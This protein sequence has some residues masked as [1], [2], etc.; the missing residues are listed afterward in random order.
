MACCECCCP[1]GKDCC[2]SQGPNGICCEPAKCCGTEQVPKCCA[3]NETCCGTACCPSDR[4]CCDGECCPQGQ[5]CVDGECSACP[6]SQTLCGEACCPDNRTCCEGV[7]CPEGECCENGECVAC[8]CDEDAD[9]ADGERCCDGVCYPSFL[10]P[11]CGGEC[12]LPPNVCCNGE[13]CDLISCRGPLSWRLANGCTPDD[14]DPTGFRGTICSNLVQYSF[15]IEQPV[16]CDGFEYDARIVYRA[17]S[18]ALPFGLRW[19][20]GYP[21]QIAPCPWTVV[22]D[23]ACVGCCKTIPGEPPSHS[24]GAEYSRTVKVLA[25]YCDGSVND[26]TADAIEGIPGEE[27]CWG[28]ITIERIYLTCVVGDPPWPA[29]TPPGT[30]CDEA[31][32][33]LPFFSVNPVCE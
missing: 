23:E 1:A 2:K 8:Q 14:S 3:S 26:V 11:D 15:D 31:R 13:C 10:V 20:T 5:T 33:F 6:E 28:R 29:G 21:E 7:C 22:I 19:K 25:K 24:G 30:T 9:C 18:G 12:C 16:F 27:A 17:I 4:V 32:E